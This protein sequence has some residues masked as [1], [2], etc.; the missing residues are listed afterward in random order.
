MEDIIL[1]KRKVKEDTIE[2]VANQ[3][4]DKITKLLINE[5]RKR[6]GIKGSAKIVEPIRNY[7][8]FNLDDNGNLKFKYGKEDSVIK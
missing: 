6:L 4:Y 8:S 2:L 5:R 1:E 3:M 7:D